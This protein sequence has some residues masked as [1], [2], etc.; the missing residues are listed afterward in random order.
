M[1]LVTE[2]LCCEKR[3]EVQSSEL[4]HMCPRCRK[5]AERI[6]VSLLKGHSW[7]W[8][9]TLIRE[10]MRKIK[11]LFYHKGEDLLFL[12]VQKGKF[13]WFGAEEAQ[14]RPDRRPTRFEGML[15]YRIP[16]K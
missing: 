16:K 7:R 5:N 3:L 14:T 4:L 2:C 8:E 10:A 15:K 6:M 1:I 11:G 13:E 9:A 12:L